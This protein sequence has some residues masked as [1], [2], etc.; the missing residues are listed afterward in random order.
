LFGIETVI[1]ACNKMD[2]VDYREDRF[3]EI[4]GS[5]RAALG[6]LGMEPAAV[7]P[8]SAFAGENVSRPSE[9]MPWYRGAPFLAALDTVAPRAAAAHGSLRFP[10]QDTYEIGGET[11]YVGKIA[12]GSLRSGDE[13]TIL[14]GSFPASVASI[15]IFGTNPRSARA[16]E[17][18]GVTLDA[19]GPA[20]RGSVLAPRDES[21]S[22]ADRF[23]GNLFWMA[24]H[25]LRVGEPLTLRCTTQDV[26][27]A[28][29]RIV[30]RIDSSTL[31]A[32]AAG[33]GLLEQNEAGIVELRASRPIVIEPFHAN[34]ELGR[35]VLERDGNV[36]G[37]GIIT[38]VDSGSAAAS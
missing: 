29:L 27:C 1:A 22:T 16:G 28:A 11:V 37:A 14:P 7:I 35:F 4:R 17:N 5:L 33:A 21:A 10:V 6:G 20:A 24:Q 30:E 18:I 15:R 32:L 13:V 2:L 8:V 12:A 36:A 26:E 23:T 34:R 31:E 25:P 9:K 3:E 38:A 19:A